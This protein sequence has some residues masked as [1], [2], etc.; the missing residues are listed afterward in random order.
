MWFDSIN[1]VMI[2]SFGINPVSGGTPARDNIAILIINVIAMFVLN[3]LWSVLI[4]FEL[5]FLIIKK[6]GSTTIEYIMKYIMQ[7]TDLLIDSIDVIHPIWPIDEYASSGRRWVWFIPSIPPI[8]AFNPEVIINRYLDCVLYSV[9]ISSDSGASFCHVDNT[10]Q[11]IHDND[12][13]TDGYQKWHGAI[14]SL[15]SI[16]IVITHIGIICVIGWYNIVIP[17]SINIDPSAWD[18]KY[19]I[20]ASVSWLDF[21]AIINGTNLNILISNIIHALNQFGLIIVVSVLIISKIYIAHKNGVW[22]S[23]K[24]WRSWTPN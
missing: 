24:I 6:I 5:M 10:I 4:V 2:I 11:L 13:I 12:A 18:R 20:D 23:I 7:N 8:N 1:L 14:P 16:A 3:R 17:R 15:I 21:V 22:L 9:I 19:L